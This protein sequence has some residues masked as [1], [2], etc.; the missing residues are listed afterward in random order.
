M[1]ICRQSMLLVLEL[2]GRLYELENYRMVCQRKTIHTSTW[3]HQQV[4][5]CIQSISNQCP[6]H[7]SSLACINALY[8]SRSHKGKQVTQPT[9]CVTWIFCTRPSPML[10]SGHGQ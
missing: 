5:R 4:P 9:T 2:Y 6:L 3:L 7:D 8:P 10:R 1:F